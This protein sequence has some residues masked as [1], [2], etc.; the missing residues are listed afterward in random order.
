M[1]GMTAYRRKWAARWGGLWGGM[2]AGRIDCSPSAAWE[3][4]ALGLLIALGLVAARM[5]PEDGPADAPQARVH[6]APGVFEAAA[7]TRAAASPDDSPVSRAAAAAARGGTAHYVRVDGGN[8]EQCDGTRDAPY[9]G[10]GRDRACAWSHPFIALPPGG[11]ARIDGGDTLVIGAGE[12]MMGEGAPGTAGCAGANCHMSPV[13]SGPSPQRP[14][15]VVAAKGARPVLWGT[16]GARRVIDLENSSNIEIAGLEIT[17]RSDCVAGHPDK[18]VAC[19]TEPPHGDW[20]RTGLYARDSRNVLLRDLR[21]HGLAHTGINAGRLRDWT[22]ERVA[23]NANGRAGWDGNVGKGASSNSGRI[24]MRDI[25][26]GWNGCA[27]RWR[28]NEPWAC[29]AQKSGGYGDGL[30]T[31]TTGGD[32]L[33]ED[34]HVH[35]NT[36]DGLDFRYMDGADSTRVTVRRLYAVANAGNQLKIRGNARVEHSVLVGRCGF[37]NGRRDRMLD[38]DHCRAGG[39]TLQLVLTP[40]DLVY[41]GNNTITGEGGALI[42]ANEGDDSARIRLQNNVLVGAPTFRKPGVRSAA[43]YANKAPAEVSWAD[44]LV[45]QVKGIGCPDNSVCNRE[46]PL[47]NLALSSFDATPR[48]NSALADKVGAPSRVARDLQRKSR[49]TAGSTSRD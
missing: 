29:W 20:A 21:I 40:G 32:W 41:V 45:W 10:S 22:L 42:G 5:L 12:Y 14:T 49:A 34:A 35:H 43:Y 8:A 25:E 13:P 23:I 1:D 24:V 4:G 46:P 39:N 47:A 19:R 33:I 37:F 2:R 28:S 11:R 27:E 18:A 48:A 38:G 36:S 26:I 9:P 3:I 7:A 17:D 6:A 30:G 31:Q 44:N 15:R 16:G